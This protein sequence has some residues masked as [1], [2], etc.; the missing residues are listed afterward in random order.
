[1]KFI[2]VIFLSLLAF[3]SF[4]QKPQSGRSDTY[5]YA[6]NETIPEDVKAPIHTLDSLVLSS[7]QRGDI[8]VF[9]GLMSSQMKENSTNLPQ[10]L[11][12]FQEFVPSWDFQY[13]D[14]FW[15]KNA[16]PGTQHPVMNKLMTYHINHISQ[17]KEEYITLNVAK[18]N[19]RSFMVF[20]IYSKVRGAWEL[21][22]FHGSNYSIFGKTSIDYFRLSQEGIDKKYILNAYFNILLSKELLK[23]GGPYFQYQQESEILALEDSLVALMNENFQMPISIDQVSENPVIIDIQPQV[24]DKGFIPLFI[25]E[26]DISIDNKPALEKQCDE[27]HERIET[28]FSGIKSFGPHVFYRVFNRETKSTGRYHGFVKKKDE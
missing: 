6:M 11:R 3:N 20:S 9:E 14:E 17:S 25:Y 19:M 15:I 16:I 13:K 23:P 10:I 5:R 4:A 21:A 26:T 2:F 28:I 8:S 1:M 24:T 22:T 27:I 7:I 18:D 12:T